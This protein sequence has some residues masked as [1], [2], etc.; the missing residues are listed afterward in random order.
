MAQQL[1]MPISES[2][3]RR[4]IFNELKEENTSIAKLT[5]LMDEEP[6]DA[7]SKQDNLINSII[8][9][10]S[11]IKFVYPS[12][13][14]YT[15]LKEYL[16]NQLDGLIQERQIK[17]A[18]AKAKAKI[19]KEAKSSVELQAEKAENEAQAQIEKLAK[20][21]SDTHHLK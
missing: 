6:N 20:I 14:D 10:I 1:D 8:E 15:L 12:S 17:E 13:A 19:A 5:K 16:S 7:I 18:A 2:T 9:K 4:L 11:K 21:Q 3:M